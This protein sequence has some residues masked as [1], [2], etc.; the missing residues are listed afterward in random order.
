MV[1]YRLDRRPGAS[2]A[3]VNCLEARAARAGVALV[4]AVVAAGKH[5]IARL[6]AVR[7][8]IL[9]R[10]PR[11]IANVLQR[12]LA[13]GAARHY[14]RR[15]RAVSGFIVLR[16]ARLFAG[17]EVTV[18]LAPTRIAALEAAVEPLGQ[19]FATSIRAD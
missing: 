2:A 15:Q 19:R 5:F 4:R 8:R 1:T 3:D 18:E 9:T 13:A 10:C 7:D 6:V 14:V 12:S 17:V 16:M 11:P